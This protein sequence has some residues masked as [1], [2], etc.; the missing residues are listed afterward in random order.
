MLTSHGQ[1]ERYGAH[2]QNMVVGWWSAVLFQNAWVRC[3]CRILS[4]TSQGWSPVIAYP[5]QSSYRKPAKTGYGKFWRYFFLAPFFFRV[6]SSRRSPWYTGRLQVVLILCA[7][8]FTSA[9]AGLLGAFDSSHLPH[10]HKPVTVGSVVFQI[11]LEINKECGLWRGWIIWLTH[12]IGTM[13][14]VNSPSLLRALHAEVL[15]FN[16]VRLPYSLEMHLD[17]A[18]SRPPPKAVKANPQFLTLDTLGITWWGECF[19]FFNLLLSWWK[20]CKFIF[21]SMLTFFCLTNIQYCRTERMKPRNMSVLSI[22]DAT[23]KALADAHIMV[24]I[25]NHQAPGLHGLRPK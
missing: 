3:I 4:T 16:C 15:G 11:S 18:E 22:F 20:V 17:K 21:Y 24:I 7:R 23:I 14:V 13:C 6:S 10:E 1:F 25:N 12:L 19:N 2:M 9:I 5:T 8:W